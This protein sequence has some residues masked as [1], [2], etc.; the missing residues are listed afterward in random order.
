MIDNSLRAGFP[1]RRIFLEKKAVLDKKGI[2]AEKGSLATARPFL[3]H[4]PPSLQNSATKY[5]IESVSN[6]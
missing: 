2:S 5:K 4:C 3:D 6:A 1:L